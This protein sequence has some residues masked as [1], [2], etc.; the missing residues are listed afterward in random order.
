M[1]MSSE[2]SKRPSLQEARRICL[3]FRKLPTSCP[4]CQQR[5]LWGWLDD[6]LSTPSNEME[7]TGIR[8]LRIPRPDQT[9]FCPQ[10]E[11]RILN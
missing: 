9:M 8:I 2:A 5:F 1:K 3:P 11:Q 10:C 6:D 7:S 4:V